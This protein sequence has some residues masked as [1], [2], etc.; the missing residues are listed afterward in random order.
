MSTYTILYF[1]V[2]RTD[3]EIELMTNIFKKNLEGNIL[4]GLK[5]HDYVRTQYPV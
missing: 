4:P 1:I 3:E 2:R 5:V